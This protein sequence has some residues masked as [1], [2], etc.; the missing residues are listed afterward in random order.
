MQRLQLLTGLMVILILSASPAGAQLDHSVYLP[1][2]IKTSLPTVHITNFN[3]EVSSSGQYLYV[4]GE[5]LNN[6]QDE[7]ATLIEIPILIYSANQL[8]EVDFTFVAHEFLKPGRSGCFDTLVANPGPSGRV[9][10][11]PLDYTSKAV[12]TNSPDFL[13]FTSVNDT[14]DG[15]NHKIFGTVQVIG[16][17]PVEALEVLFTRYDAGGDVVDCDYDYLGGQVYEPGQSADFKDEYFGDHT[18]DHYRVDATA[19]ELSPDPAPTSTDVPTPTHTPTPTNTPTA[20]DTP[21][22]TPT[23]TPTPTPTPTDILSTDR[24]IDNGDG[25]VWDRETNLIWLQYVECWPTF[26]GLIN[27]QTA[28]N[29][30]AALADGQ[31]R[32]TDGSS[33][34]DW[35]LPTKEEWEATIADALVLGCTYENAS[36]PSLTDTAGTGCYFDGPQIFG[37][38]EGAF[39]W[40]STTSETDPT[41]VWRMRLGDG[42][43]LIGT[44]GEGHPAWPVREGP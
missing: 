35:R 13:H 8:I 31:C 34:G 2:I 11:G 21:T 12:I 37:V 9:E 29:N 32:L 43:L 5:V 39:Y 25:T 19:V 38:V 14:N 27:W 33:A 15:L 7:V 4:R 17:S 24:Y 36:G 3:T 6:T 16:Q 30:A 40:T 28:T 20:T 1:A 23:H 10:L 22:S 26:A 41:L 42:A 44:K 18:V